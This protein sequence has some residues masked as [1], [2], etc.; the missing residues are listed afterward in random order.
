[1]TIEGPFG[2]SIVDSLPGI[3]RRTVDDPAHGADARGAVDADR[4]AADAARLIADVY[5]DR[6]ER[7][8]NFVFIYALPKALFA[9]FGIEL[10]S[11][12][13]YVLSFGFFLLGILV[14]MLA[15]SA[16]AEPGIDSA[17]V[18][19]LSVAASLAGLNVLALIMAQAAAYKISGLHRALVD[20]D[21]IRSLIRWDRRWYSPG[22]SALTGT[23][24][25]F[26][27]LAVLYE[28]T[29]RATGID[30]SPSTLWVCLIVAMFLGQFSFSTAMVF[31]EFRTFTA[32]RFDL[33][34][35]SPIQTEAL[36]RTAAGLKQLG[37]VS[38]VLLPLFL[39][40]LLSVLPAGS[41][42]NVPIT[43][44][45][46]L[47]AY[48]AAAVGILFPLAFLGTIVKAEKQRR[49]RPLR[50]R[51]NDMVPRLQSLTD[52]EYEEFKRLQ[53]L[54]AT[55]SDSKDSLLD[56]GSVARITGAVGLSTLT[57][58]ATSLVQSYVQ[59]LR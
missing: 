18:R 14:P 30:L 17:P 22:M 48:L 36:Q 46:L 58:V 56:F 34:A 8:D 12:P 47:L 50:A 53:S 25:A 19:A 38:I 37:A 27:F 16:I 3:P 52:A 11:G 44:G 59:H 29:L 41:N 13:G 2:E 5:A 4:P 32:C 31:F 28:L 57:V 7:L 35:L 6:H 10:H 9:R 45:F 24:I 54:H 26:G 49:L 1:M 42:L 33:Y 15:I 43:G 23:L 39:L 51:L 21:Q 55:I 40:V 20:E